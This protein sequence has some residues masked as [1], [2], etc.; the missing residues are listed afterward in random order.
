MNEVVFLNLLQ[1]RESV[2]WVKYWNVSIY[3]TFIINKKKIKN[4]ITPLGSSSVN[5]TVM[6]DELR[7]RIVVKSFDT[8]YKKHWH[9]RFIYD[10]PCCLY[11]V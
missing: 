1:N 9:F 6:A 5:S 11:I 2:F 4:C 3:Y 10:V 8:L 7:V